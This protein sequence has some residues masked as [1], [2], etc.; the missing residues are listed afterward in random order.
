V[1]VDEKPR[2]GVCQW[3][4]QTPPPEEQ[5]AGLQARVAAAS[6][7]LCRRVAQGTIR[8]ILEQ[9]GQAGIQTLLDMITAARIEELA[10]VLTPDMVASLKGVLAAANVEHRDLPLA[11]MLEELTVLEEDRL[12]EFLKKLRERLLAAFDRAKRETGGKKQVRFFLK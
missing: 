11:N 4:G 1:R 2:C 5:A 8:K 3:D 7:E 9:S 12:D 6:K 10:R